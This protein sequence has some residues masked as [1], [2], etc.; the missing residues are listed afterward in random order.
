MAAHAEYQVLRKR[1]RR[2]VA[3]PLV[4]GGGVLAGIAAGYLV[5]GRRQPKYPLAPSR[6]SAW[7]QV[8]GSLRVLT[9]LWIALRSAPRA[10]ADG[11][12]KAAAGERHE[13]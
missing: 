12:E 4:I 6:P 5:G 13:S 3:S 8:L 1:L 2:R 9:P 11:G 7:M 10:Q